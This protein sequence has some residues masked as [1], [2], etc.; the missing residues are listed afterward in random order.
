M[1][2]VGW[3]WYLRGGMKVYADSAA[4]ARQ[5]LEADRG[6]TDEYYLAEGTGITRRF[7]A[8][9]AGVVQLTPLAGTVTRRG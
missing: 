5:Y 6:R 3:R 2:I 7:A 1:V 4:P 9:E 8:G